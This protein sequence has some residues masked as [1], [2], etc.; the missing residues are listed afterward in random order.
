VLS[1]CDASAITDFATRAR[2]ALGDNV[3]D[4]R[5]F[6]SKAT[7][8]DVADSD[9]DILAVVQAASV[10]VE[11][12]VLAIAFDV[13]LAHDVYISHRVIARTTL[14]DPVWQITP[15]VQAALAGVPV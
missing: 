14:D 6:G 9:I 4:M 3:L 1:T 12:Q 13:N 11:D 10:G 15:F 8:R 5:P 2:T 7:R